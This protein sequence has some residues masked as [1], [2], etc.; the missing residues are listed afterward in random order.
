MIKATGIHKFFHRNQRHEVHALNDITLQLPDKGLVVLSGVSGSGKTTLLNVLSGLDVAQ[1]GRIKLADKTIS[2]DDAKTWDKVR[3]ERIGF[4]FQDYYLLPEMSVYDNVAMPLRMLGIHDEQAIETRVHYM[5]SMVGMYIYRKR[6]ASQ[7][8]GGQRQRVA[9]ARALVKNPRVIFADEPTGNLDSKTTIDIL[10]IIKKI[11]RERLVVLVTHEHEMAR[12]YGDRI[13]ELKDGKIIN[14]Q[15]NIP[16]RTFE[17]E[18]EDTLFLKEFKHVQKQDNITFYS[19]RDDI[20]LT[21]DIQVAL[22]YKNDTL[23]LDVQGVIRKMKLIMP[24]NG[25]EVK[26]ETYGNHLENRLIDTPFNLDTLDHEQLDKKKQGLVFSIKD[27][28]QAALKRI[29]R[30]RY[31]GKIMLLGFILSGMIIAFS[32]SILG[33]YLFNREVFVEELEAN[34]TVVK[35]TYSLP[36]ET[37]AQFGEGDDTFFINPYQGETIRITIPSIT[38]Q[39]TTY[40]LKGRIDLIDH[41]RPDQIIAGRMPEHDYEFVIDKLVYEKTNG[42]YN[43]LTRQGIWHMR[44]LLGEKVHLYDKTFTIVGIT[45]TRAQRIY[46]TRSGATLLAHGPFQVASSYVSYEL[47]NERV[48][49][50]HGRMPVEGQR[51]LLAPSSWFGIVIP[52]FAFHEG[53]THRYRVY[54]LSGLYDE[55]VL[56]LPGVQPFVGYNT[57]IEYYIFMQSIGQVYV[58]TAEPGRLVGQLRSEGIVAQW[59]FGDS[60]LIARNTAA[61]MLPIL[62]VS[63]FIVFLSGMGIFFMMRSSMLSRIYEISVYRALGISNERLKR[64]FYIEVAV[65]T[66][67]SALFGYL[68]GVALVIRTYNITILSYMF[69]MNVITAVFGA[70]FIYVSNMLFG[71]LSVQGILKKTPAQLLSQYDL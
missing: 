51:E 21:K 30:M 5:L 25:I 15:P 42:Q 49:L 66:T 45:D 58:H 27:S 9:I 2:T 6:K 26:D 59:D 20:D 12:Y 70:L 44:Q 55:S 63:L 34:V 35:Q 29:A 71:V 39:Q 65:L 41:I 13:I 47:F 40:D 11:S 69:Y 8:S 38:G 62:F 22:I 16:E 33:N 3:T 67:V 19:N 14:D 61:K 7:L 37:I 32:A 60:V 64:A 52:P 43:V 54:T 24:G 68:V 10:K 18:E 56:D 23:Y 53:S 28:I 57:D 48:V 50:T 17:I 4:I 46:A 36:Y 1:S 31:T